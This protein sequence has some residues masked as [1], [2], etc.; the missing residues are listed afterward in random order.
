MEYYERILKIKSKAH[1]NIKEA[2]HLE[3]T[4]EVIAN[5]RILEEVKR[6]ENSL[7]A[8]L[9]S[10]EQ[11]FENNILKEVHIENENISGVNSVKKYSAKE[12]GNLRRENFIRKLENLGINLIKEKGV[13][14]RTQNGN[15]IGIASA[16]ELLRKKEYWF[17][18]L[19]NKN[20][21]TVVLICESSKGKVFNFILPKYIYEQNENK[22]S[23]DSTNEQLK[24]NISFRNGNFQ[25]I[26][27]QVDP[28][29]I[30]DYID[31]ISALGEL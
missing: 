25:M 16:S 7:D 27:P 31:N 11:K 3:K 8:S 10:L 21:D 17:L 4:E 1:N 30:N 13:I 12:K 15:R 29:S 2:A 24:F 22:F 18:G 19:P 5:T 9:K 20:Y 14:Y 26:I 28:I 6:L 23:R